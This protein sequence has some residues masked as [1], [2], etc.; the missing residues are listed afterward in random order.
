LAERPVR[1]ALDRA[2]FEPA[3]SFSHGSQT[4]AVTWNHGQPAV[5]GDSLGGR[6]ELMPVVRVIG[7]DPL[8]QFLVRFPGGRLQTLEASWD[9]RTN[10]W[11]NVYGAEDRKPG[12]WGHW[13]GR[14][15]NWNS[16]CG[17]CH[18]TRFRKYYEPEIDEYRS[19]MAEPTVGCEACHGPLKD[20]VTWQRAF[21]ST[22]SKDP[23][24]TLKKRSPAEQMEACAPCHARRGELTGDFQPGDSF[25]DHFLLSMVDESEVFYADGQVREE[26]YEYAAFLGSRMHAAGVTCLDCHDSH[27]AE[28][29]VLG[30]ELC[31]RCHNGSRLGSPIIDPVGHSH[32]AANSPGAACVDCH[33]PTTVFMQ[34]HGRHDH[35]FT[36]PDPVLTQEFG[37]PNACNRCHA[38]RD[39]EWARGICETWYGKAK[40]DRP[41][42]AR[43][44][45][46]AR[47][48]RGEAAGR[49]ALLSLVATP[50]VPYWR[51]SALGL[52][53]RWVDDEPVRRALIENLQHRHPMVRHRAVQSLGPRVEARDPGVID[54][55]RSR[56]LDPAR[57]VRL[58][59]AWALR[60]ESVLDSGVAKDLDRMLRLNAD[61]PT[62]QA[63]LAVFALARG[64]QE[65]AV[66]HYRRAVAW[67]PGSP[68]FRQDFAVA[69]SG[70][71]RNREALEQIQE[72]VR[73]QPGEAENHFRLGL[74][75]AE[76]GDLALAAAAM[77]EAARLDPRHDRAL[78][79][80]GLAYHGLAR[81]EEA[82]GILERA[83]GIQPLDPRSPYARATILAQ[84]GR[85]REARAAAEEALRR[86][87]GYAPA[88]ELLRSLPR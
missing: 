60:G 42:R 82:L 31:L 50:E 64:R 75:Q 7:H 51:A 74:A 19:T 36:S 37:I 80:L 8:R 45:A 35:G 71:G 27:A 46:V 39:A 61:Q 56:L 40:M 88:L 12:E 17:T 25:W 84:M 41:A 20:H 48:R 47:A 3:R 28:P 57:N 83:A 21:R 63:Q 15:M 70:V 4:T 81:S 9:P 1:E 30:N 29:R 33:M 77:E 34:R 78:Y 73:L 10:E 23:D 68:V 54:A 53:G 55:V 44:R 49:D 85:T 79:N 59:A 14:G 13:T 5:E 38:D 69:L 67:D 2:A 6:R 18:N 24:P 76:L 58:A 26:D 72:A 43:T 65:A 22:G 16:M 66:E 87:P 32:H 62:G 86:Q 52:L 11:F